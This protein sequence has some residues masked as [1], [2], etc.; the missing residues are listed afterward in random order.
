MG[1]WRKIRSPE[2]IKVGKTGGAGGGW[3]VLLLRALSVNFFPSSFFFNFS[4]FLSRKMKSFEAKS[5]KSEKKYKAFRNR[6]TS[7]P[8]T[9]PQ[10]HPFCQL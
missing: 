6:E 4:L 1:K 8:S 2:V 10:P 5:N 9:L 7:A 3:R